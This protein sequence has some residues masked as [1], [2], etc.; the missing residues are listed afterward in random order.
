MADPSNIRKMN[1]ETD[2]EQVKKIWQHMVKKAHP[3]ISER[4]WESRLPI[5]IEE[6]RNAKEKYIYKANGKV[7]GF[8]IV[9]NDGYIFEL[10]IEDGFEGQ[11]IGIALFKVLQGKY[12]RFT[13]SVYAHNHK[14]F[15]WHIKRGFKVRGVMFCSHTGLPKFEMIWEKDKE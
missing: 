15:A 3:L 8:I 11:G 10:Y 9:R 1:L 13:S 2:L 12:S 4:F 7:V 6:T 5:M 14:S